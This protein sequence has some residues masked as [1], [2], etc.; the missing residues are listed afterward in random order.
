MGKSLTKKVNSDQLTEN[1]CHSDSVSQQQA[2]SYR[3][4]CTSSPWPEDSKDWTLVKSGKS[5]HSG[6]SGKKLELCGDRPLSGQ[7]PVKC[8]VLYVR[9]IHCSE[10]QTDDNIIQQVKLYTKEKGVHVVAARVV[11]NRFAD[12]IEKG[13]RV[14]VPQD[15]AVKLLDVRFWPGTH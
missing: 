10:E 15:D 2:K 6:M 12:D 4:A 5:H 14:T 3:D 11:K 8:K 9:K 7:R 13:C 1:T